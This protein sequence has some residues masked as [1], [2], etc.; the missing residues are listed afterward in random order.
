MKEYFK[1]LEINKKIQEILDLEKRTKTDIKSLK[2]LHLAKKIAIK[3]FLLNLRKKCFSQ[4]KIYNLQIDN[5]F[6]N[7]FP[8]EE[9][10]RN[11]FNIKQNKKI[12]FYQNLIDNEITNI[13]RNLLIMLYYS[14]IKQY[15][16]KYQIEKT[17]KKTE[18]QIFINIS[19]FNI[20]INNVN[21]YYKYYYN[22]NK[23]SMDYRP[24]RLEIKC[25]NILLNYQKEYIKD[26]IEIDNIK[27]K[28]K[29]NIIYL[30]NQELYLIKKILIRIFYKLKKEGFLTDKI[31]SK[32]LLKQFC[33][34][35]NNLLKNEKNLYLI[36]QNL[37]QFYGIL[38]LLA[39]KIIFYKNKKLFNNK[40]YH[41]KIYMI[42][43][44]HFAKSL[45]SEIY[46]YL[47]SL[48][49]FIILDF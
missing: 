47:N 44:N 35:I 45:N 1:L 19:A 31:L 33:E 40:Y 17:I 23:I 36:F 18:K 7:F 49:K 21:D 14:R 2:Y 20:F 11:K 10:I 34:Y 15:N 39:N 48:V 42:I 25:N 22:Y 12:Y 30:K 16:K 43:N 29:Y 13:I 6:I 26:Y 27:I 5:N 28:K 37:I 3:N 4:N 32:F 46:L 38:Y 9:I 8:T 24:N 41:N